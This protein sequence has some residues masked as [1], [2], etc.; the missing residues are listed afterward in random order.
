MVELKKLEAVLGYSFKDRHILSRALTHT[1]M[2]QSAKSDAASYE[3]LEFLGDRVLGLVMAQWLLA[4]FPDENEG[5]IAKR[6]AA[7]VCGDTLASIAQDIAIGDYIVMSEAEKKSG[8]QR[9]ETIL[10]DCMEA[11]LGAVYS[12][13]GLDVAQTLIGTVW[14]DR[15]RHN[16]EPPVDY[17][18]ALQERLQA[19]GMP[20]PEY[21]FI[22]REG[23]DHQPVFTVECR[24]EN[25]PVVT[26]VAESK[27]A[28]EKL[29]AEKMLK[30]LESKVKE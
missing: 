13:G 24:V 20:L 9:K 1:S 6:H 28:A 23:P 5:A 21:R 3:R 12:D 2:T 10:A 22:D 25:E 19:R 26:A 8:G 17:K 16:L 27:K 30:L 11:I 18:S 4:E 14:K 15:I 29:A 7:L